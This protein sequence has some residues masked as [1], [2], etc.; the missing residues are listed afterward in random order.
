MYRYSSHVFRDDLE[1]A[2]VYKRAGYVPEHLTEEVK[3]F[4]T[5][6]M[7]MYLSLYDHGVLYDD[8]FVP[9]LGDAAHRGTL[10]RHQM[11]LS[12]LSPHRY[13]EGTAGL[14]Q[15]RCGREVHQRS[16]GGTGYPQDIRGPA[17]S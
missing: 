7:Y 12:Q 14:S 13:Q 9:G 15:A 16:S 10:N 11:P 2:V 1:V 3:S 5:A 8:V 17:Q 6:V 4:S